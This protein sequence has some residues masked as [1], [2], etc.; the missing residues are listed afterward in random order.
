M[1]R[2]LAQLA[3]ALWDL[4]VSGLHLIKQRENAVFRVELA[5]GGRKA[6]RV[7]RAGYHSD[8]ALRSEAQW[9][10]ALAEAGL[11]V[12]R[13]VPSRRGHSFERVEGRQVDVLD[14]VDGV[15]LGS[16]EAG[17]GDDLAGIARQYELVGATMARM[18]EQA[19]GWRH[20]A[21]FERHS[22]CA[23]GLAGEQPLWGRF[24]ELAALEPAQRTLML[25]L[26]DA[27]REDLARLPRDEGCFGLIHADLV[28][29]NLLVHQGEVHVIDFDDA[30]HGW[31][32]FDLATS[33]Y[34]LQGRPGYGTARQALVAGYRR[35]R[36]LPDDSLQALL[37]MFLAARGSTYLGWVHERHHTET[38]RQLTPQ[39]I[40]LACAAAGDYLRERP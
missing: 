33:L 19:A 11:R 1:S 10:G 29:E 2:D 38:A 3:L 30:G 13:L 35:H 40:E 31:H 23:D 4:D 37:P 12:P 8:A 5:G 20:G 27:L 26:R 24:W 34:F 9:L 32:L 17:I 18:H 7:H 36:A 15:Q 28:P 39:L 6:L 16:V 22:W 14:W 21:G 25:R